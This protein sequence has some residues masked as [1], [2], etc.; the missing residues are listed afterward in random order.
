MPTVTE[1]VLD[2][3]MTAYGS[4]KTVR[5]NRTRLRRAIEVAVTAAYSEGYRKGFEAAEYNDTNVK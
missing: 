5:A 1:E 2:A 3:A 4:N